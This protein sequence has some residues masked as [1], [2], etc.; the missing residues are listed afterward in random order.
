MVDIYRGK[1][2]PLSSTMRLIIDLVNTTQAEQLADQRVTLFIII[3]RQKS[4]C[5]SAPSS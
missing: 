2:P 4:F 3:Y 1:Y 5:F